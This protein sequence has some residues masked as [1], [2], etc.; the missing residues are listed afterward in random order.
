M[1]RSPTVVLPGSAARSEQR[2]VRA[3][4]IAVVALAAGGLAGIAGL[5]IG[6]QTMGLMADIDQGLG[7]ALGG[8]AT[9]AAGI[10]GARMLGRPIKPIGRSLGE[11]L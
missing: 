1:K 4:V 6:H 7:M 8:G 9:Y 5:D 3:A 11:I 10:A 2:P